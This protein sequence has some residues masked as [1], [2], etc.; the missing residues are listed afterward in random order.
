MLLLLASTQA[1]HFSLVCQ[2]P[3]ILLVET[4]EPRLCASVCVDGG[5][6]RRPSEAEVRPGRGAAC[7][8]TEPESVGMRAARCW[9]G[10]F[11]LCGAV[12]HWVYQMIENNLCF[13]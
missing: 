10:L 3:P 13:C 12:I 1:Q 8:E 6:A 7:W 2:K 5:I 11:S 9:F 4:C